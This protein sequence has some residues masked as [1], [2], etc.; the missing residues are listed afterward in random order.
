LMD[1][2]KPDYGVAAGPDE[3][4][5]HFEDILH[6]KLAD[7]SNLLYFQ[8]G[9]LKANPVRFFPPFDKPEYTTEVI[10]QMLA[11]NQEFPSQG[12]QGAPVEISRGCC[13]KCVFCSEPFGKG[14]EVRY[15]KISTI[16]ADIRMLVEHG[17]RNIYMISSELNPEGN[18]FVLKLADEI[19]AFNQSQPE[20]DKVTWFGANYL[21]KFSY[22]EHLRLNRSGFTGGWFDI[23]ALDD[24]NARAMKTPYR[25]A[26]LLDDLKSFS[27]AERIRQA[28]HEQNIPSPEDAKLRWTMFMG[29]PA[30]TIETVH[31][32][33][34]I[35][36]REGFAREFSNCSLFTVMRVFD[37]ENL[38]DSALEVTFSI[39]PELEETTYNQLLPHRYSDA[40]SP[41]ISCWFYSR[42]IKRFARD[43]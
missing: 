31:K 4:F 39:T 14:P 7:V 2:L 30:T 15:R 33:L 36:N 18:E 29:N 35:A 12:L 43:I 26:Q 13:H 6:G 41:A 9:N 40:E 10:E 37:Y 3:F 42:W 17:I 23:T 11:F 24:K 28:E 22:E 34:E 27:R 5:L 19:H 16:M 8:D 38:D 21:L 20:D 25:N 32:T 1:Y